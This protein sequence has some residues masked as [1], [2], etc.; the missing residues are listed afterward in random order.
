MKTMI[1][2]LPPTYRRQQVARKRAIQWCSVVCAVLMSGWA[3]HW[4]E[5]REAIVLSQ[6]L[7]SLEREQAPTQT[8]L[9][10][11][12]VM[13][14]KLDDLQ[15]QETVAQELEY[16]RNAL[17]L[18]GVVSDTARATK[19]RLRVTKLELTDF[20]NTRRAAAAPAGSA[21]GSGLVLAG[22]SLDNPAVAELL[23][24]LQDSGIF[25]RVE[26]LTLKE[27]EN[28]AESLRD[29]EVRCEF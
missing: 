19:G 8:M 16:Q 22:V 6:Q 28:S 25:S 18:L 10:Q 11:L 20:Q 21:P 3:W 27:R 23:D 15:Q 13:R 26:L 2:I 24:G 17:T 9:K 4:C 29:Y 7:E 14:Q 1:N 5:Q 12:V